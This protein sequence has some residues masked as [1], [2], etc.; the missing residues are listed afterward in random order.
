MEKKAVTFSYE[1]KVC[2]CSSRDLKWGDLQVYIKHGLNIYPGKV[3][4]PELVKSCLEIQKYL[5]RLHLNFQ[6]LSLQHICAKNIIFRAES[7]KNFLPT[8]LKKLC[9]EYLYDEL[10]ACLIRWDLAEILSYHPYTEIN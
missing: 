8:P 1:G 2:P 7:L 9:Q 3:V 5:L 6:P 10:T 4:T